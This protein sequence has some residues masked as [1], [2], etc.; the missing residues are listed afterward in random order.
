[1]NSALPKVD[2]LKGTNELPLKYSDYD[3]DA[4]IVEYLPKK[5]VNLLSRKSGK[6]FRFTF[7][8][9]DALGLWTP[10]KKAS[11]F[12]CLEPWNGLPAD[13]DETT[14]AK[15]K[16][17]AITIASGEEYTVAYTVEIIK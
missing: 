12:I 2:A 13:V 8:G 4:M 11:P 14:D 17:Y 5:A 6:G 3:N 9:F 1:M 7:D 15:S 10:I 16:K